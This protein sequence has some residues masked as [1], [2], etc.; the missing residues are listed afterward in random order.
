M[1][2][3]RATFRLTPRPKA[4]NAADAPRVISSVPWL[5]LVSESD[6]LAE[7][8]AASNLTRPV[9]R[10]ETPLMLFLLSAP[11]LEFSLVWLGQRE[12]HLL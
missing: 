11:F 6:V 4:G 3:G 2:D 10:L 8:S 5:G 9:L 7:G 12:A 1:T